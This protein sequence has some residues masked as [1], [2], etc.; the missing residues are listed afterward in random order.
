M[1]NLINNAH[2]K[3]TFTLHAE[4]VLGHCKNLSGTENKHDWTASEWLPFWKHIWYGT[5]HFQKQSRATAL[6]SKNRS[7]DN[8]KHFQCKQKAYPDQYGFCDTTE[9]YNVIYIA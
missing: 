1:N 6:H 5:H 2:H 3:A 7:E 9:S 4:K 8:A